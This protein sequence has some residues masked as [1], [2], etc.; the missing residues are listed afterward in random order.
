MDFGM[1]T[2]LTEI[3]TDGALAQFDV[4]ATSTTVSG[5]IESIEFSGVSPEDNARDAIVDLRINR[6]GGR[7][8]QSSGTRVAIIRDGQW[9]WRTARTEPF[10]IAALN[11]VQPADDLHLRA[12]RT[13]FGNAQVFLAP[14]SD[15]SSS[16]VALNGTPPTSPLRP[17]LLHGVAA[18]DPDVDVY[19]AIAAFAASRGVGARQTNE[20]I[21]LS[22]GTEIVIRNGKVT[23]VGGG[24][25]FDDV[26]ADAFLTSVEHQFL[27][28]GRFPQAVVS[29]N[30]VAGRALVQPQ[31]QPPFEVTMQV[32][33]TVTEQTATWAWADPNLTGSPAAQAAAT[34]RGFAVDNGIPQFLSPQFSPPLIDDYIVAVKPIVGL[35]THTVVPL[36][37]QTHASVLLGGPQLALPQPLQAAVDATVAALDGQDFSAPRRERALGAYARHRGLTVGP[38]G[39]ITV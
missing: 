11:E 32:I 36:A 38:D 26:V 13:L 19:R 23:N 35:W 16:V 15:G 7:S 27:Y 2:S 3:V 25:S 34:V 20:G 33:V 28:D 30:L 24:L 39:S 17:A 1:P 31:G 29:P 21:A 9:H 14:H 10:D 22:D 18:L 5:L 37:P 4:D 8:E 12:A 6:T